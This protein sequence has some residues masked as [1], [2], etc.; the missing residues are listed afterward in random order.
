MAKENV[1]NKELFSKLMGNFQKKADPLKAM[2]EWL[3]EKL[4]EAEMAE[5]MGADKYER[6]GD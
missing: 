5:K 1:S 3:T 6:S 2:F 4:M